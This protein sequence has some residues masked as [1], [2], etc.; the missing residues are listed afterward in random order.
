[1]TELIRTIDTIFNYENIDIRVLG[2]YK[3]PLFVV[4]EICKLLDIANSRDKI[5]HIP[6]EIH[7]AR[8]QTTGGPQKV[9]LVTEAG[10]YWLIMSTTKPEAF[11]FQMWVCKEVLPSIRKTGQYKLDEERLKLLEE[12][13]ILEKQKIQLQETNWELCNQLNDKKFKPIKKTKSII[14]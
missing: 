7:K 14:F 10:M 3:E 4:N 5:S 13:K 1:M 8:I 6:D 11:K 12:N 2:T 9:N